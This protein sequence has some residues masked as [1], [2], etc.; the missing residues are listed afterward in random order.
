[1]NFNLINLEQINKI[2][3]ILS[4]NF[5]D[6]CDFFCRKGSRPDEPWNRITSNFNDPADEPLLNPQ[7]SK[8]SNSF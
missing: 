8:L 2:N 5:Q 4:P 7:E 3:L 6:G 1:M